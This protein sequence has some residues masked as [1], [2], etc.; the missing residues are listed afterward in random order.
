MTREARSVRCPESVLGW[1]P[2]YGEGTEDGESVLTPRQRGAVEAHAAE[3]ADCRAELDMI[4]GAPFEID[5]D[6]PDPDR[7]FEEITARI[8]AGEAD[9]AAEADAIG[10]SVIPIG[11]GRPLA[12][13]DL[14][15]VARWVF[16]E[17]SEA[18]E[19]PETRAGRD[20]EADG[21]G[22]AAGRAGR[23]GRA[24]NP[25]AE[26]RVIEGPWSGGAAWMTAAAVALL[27]L[28]GLLGG[29]GSAL[30]T[31][32]PSGAGAVYDLA[33]ADRASAGPLIDVV[34]VDSA[35]AGEISRALRSAGVEIVSGPSSLGVYRLRP[36]AARDGASAAD[37]PDATDTSDGSS[38]AD[39]AEIA[40]RLRASDG[41]IVLF[42]EAV[43]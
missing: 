13:E 34:F 11:R 3:C 10:S 4:A 21:R 28:G 23:A 38:T 39:A 7:M 26:G 43:P 25:A 41:P 12:E 17:R 1:I 20:A 2:W 15:Q 31:D 36:Q 5:V 14:A 35:S 42:A 40:A 29:L 16:D 22:P 18:A 32:A 24:G 19:A 37:T 8:D 6:L 30:F 27:V 9:A 33:S